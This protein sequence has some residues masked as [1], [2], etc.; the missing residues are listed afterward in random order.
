MLAANALLPGTVSVIFLARGILALKT[1]AGSDIML[2]D[3]N[4]GTFATAIRLT[5]SSVYC[6]VQ[7]FKIEDEFAI[8]CSCCS[9][10]LESRNFVGG[11]GS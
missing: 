7:V 1:C 10:A 4:L 3:H 5:C 6:V 9:S 2:L 8:Q 11:E